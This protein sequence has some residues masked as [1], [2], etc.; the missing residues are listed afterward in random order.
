M[1]CTKKN[2]LGLAGTQGVKYSEAS[3]ISRPVG[4]R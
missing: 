2:P 4:D 3:G 1:L